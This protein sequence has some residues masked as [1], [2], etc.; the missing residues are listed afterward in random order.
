METP[1]GL[2]VRVTGVTLTWWQPPSQ[3]THNYMLTS[4]LLHTQDDEYTVTASLQPGIVHQ[5]QASVC[6]CVCV[7]EDGQSLQPGIVHQGQASVCLCVCVIE[8]GE[9]LQPGIVHQ[10]Q[11][12]V[13]VCVYLHVYV[14]VSDWWRTSL[15]PGIVHQGQASVCVCVYLHVCV[16]VCEWLRTDKPST[17][18]CSPGSG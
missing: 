3:V 14:C 17:W 2:V 7:I 15:Q 1:W 9:S 8:D 11:A 13:C 5:G 10:V 4:L 12:N 16:C 18:D 6:V